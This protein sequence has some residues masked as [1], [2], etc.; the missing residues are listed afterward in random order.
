L[1]SFANKLA[2]TL[3][4]TFAFFANKRSWTFASFANTLAWTFASFANKL[5]WT[6]ASF[7]CNFAWT[8]AS[9]LD[10]H[11]GFIASSSLVDESA[12]EAEL[13]LYVIDDMIVHLGLLPIWRVN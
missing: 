5:A 7:A 13:G 3:A 11:I 8:F 10:K 9:A 4:W 2:C 12:I 6:F 1:A